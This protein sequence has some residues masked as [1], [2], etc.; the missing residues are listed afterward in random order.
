[1]HNLNKIEGAVKI[2]EQI[3]IHA[4]YVRG[5]VNHADGRPT[6]RAISQ[7]SFVPEDFERERIAIRCRQ[8]RGLQ[9]GQ[10]ISPQRFAHRGVGVDA[11]NQRVIFAREHDEPRY[12]V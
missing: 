1:L 8:V 9:Y 7:P 4:L 11:A 5:V 10:P 12:Y 3:A 2:S 6:A